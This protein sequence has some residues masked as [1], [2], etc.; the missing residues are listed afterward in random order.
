[1]LFLRNVI[2]FKIFV[3]NMDNATECILCKF[4]IGIKLCGAASALQRRDDIQ[5]DIDRLERCNLMKFMQRPTT[6]V[7]A[8]TLI[9]AGHRME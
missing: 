7:K 1:M 9:L 2:W 8:Q 3:G 6:W 5:R 4:D